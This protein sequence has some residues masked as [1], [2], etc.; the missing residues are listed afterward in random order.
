MGRINVFMRKML[1]KIKKLVLCIK[2]YGI[3]QGWRYIRR[4]YQTI[5][6]EY[7]E[8]LEFHKIDVEI[9]DNQKKECFLFEPL[10]SILVPVYN[11]PTLFLKE[12][13][14]SVCSQ[15]YGNWELCVANANPDN[16]IVDEIL[17]SFAI[18]D[19]RIKILKLQN[20]LGIAQNTNAILQMANGDYIGLLDHDD[21]LAPDALYQ[22][23]KELNQENVPEI[24]YSDE[25][26]IT[27]DSKEHFQPHFKPDFNLDLLR[28][29]NY[30][31]HFFVVKKG[32]IDDIGGFRE[33]YNGAQ[34]YDLILRCVEK[35]EKISHIPQV[36][37]HWRIHD[38][39]TADNPASKIYAYEAGKRAIQE[40][41]NRSGEKGSVENSSDLGFYHVKY[42]LM[43][44]SLIS[45][46]IV[47]ENNMKALKNCIRSL[48]SSIYHSYEIILMVSDNQKEN[49]SKRLENVSDSNLKLYFYKKDESWSEIINQAVEFSNG[50]YILLLSQMTK[51]K[52]KTCIE[53]L[54]CNCQR[55]H[56]GVVGAK[57]YYTNNKIRYAGVVVKGDG[58]IERVFRGFPNY[59]VGYM[60]RESL[61][62]NLSAVS[63]ECMMIKKEVFEEVGGMDASLG[64]TYAAIDFCL[65]VRRQGFLI[66]FNPYA[67]LYYFKNRSKEHFFSQNDIDFMKIRWKGFLEKGDPSYNPNLGENYTIK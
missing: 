59:Y 57:L 33:K 29:N 51:M 55:K 61:Q 63:E 62:Q 60:H 53:E 2:Q 4:K 18:K 65:K 14:M 20:N 13:L 25:D 49:F 9:L 48:K 10:I 7:K 8:W 24:I 19:D 38:A 31:C 12:M 11:T 6:K 3:V 23:V 40:H 21:M 52:N 32:L 30:I 45:I 44:T 22:V 58:S 43:G 26:K 27:T 16:R 46:I 54:I 67:E 56:V 17:E 5:D 50:E 1:K 36:L 39:S 66:V 47:Y 41:L 34:D 28:S 15:T 35:T 37:Y 42:E 64:E